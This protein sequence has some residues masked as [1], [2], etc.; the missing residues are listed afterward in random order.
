MSDQD[1]VSAIDSY[2]LAD[3]YTHREGRVFLTGTQALVRV[4]LDQR[5]RDRAAGLNT[6]GYVSGYRGSPLGG[7]D[8]ELTRVAKLIA[9]HKIEFLPAVN[10]DLAATA[11]LG[12][13]QVET[14]PDRTVEGVFGMWYGKGPGVDRSGDALKHG[15]AYGSS[16]HGGVLVVA[17]DDHGCV[18]SS[19]PHQSDAAFLSWFMP[20]LNPANVAEFLPYA[21]YGYALSRFSGMWVGFKAISETVESGMSVEL[22]PPREFVTP[23]FTAP[24]G[25]LHYRWPDLPGPQIETRME[26]KKEAVR[27]FARANPLDGAIWGHDARYGIVTTGKGHLDLMEA[28]RLLGIDQARAKEIGLDVYKVGMVWPLEHHAALAFAEDKDELLVVEEKRGIIESQLKEY[29]YDYPGRKPGRMVGKRDEHGERLIPWTGEL[30]ATELAKIVAKRLDAQIEGLDLSARAARLGQ[31]VPQIAVPGATRT[32]YF[33][34][35]CPHSTSTRVPEGSQAMAG[36][37]CHFMASWM[38]RDTTSLI[39]MGGEGVNWVSRSLFNGKKHIFQNLGEGTYYHSGS[40]AIRQAVAAGT[41]I[42]FKILYNDAVAMTG[43]QPVD[44]PVSVQAIAHEMKAEGAG[45][46]A[47]VSDAPEKFDREDF[48]AG[49]TIDHRDELDR[50]QRE[51]REVPGVTVLIYEQ[52]CATEKRRRRKRGL[53][54][55]PKTFAVINDLV[56]EGCGDC[57][58]E[59]N[60]LSVEPKE[61]VFGRK[62]QINQNTCNKDMSCLNGFCPSFVT[63]RG[64]TLKKKAAGRA[65]DAFDRLAERLVAPEM[66]KLREPYD[67]LVTGVGGTGVVT[68][69]QVLAMAAHLEGKGASVLDFMGFAQKFGPVLSYLRF[70]PKPEALNQVRIEAT[71]A[72][73]VIAC[74]LVVSSSPKASATYAEGRTRMALNLAQMPTGDFTRNRSADLRSEERRRRIAKT[75]G[76]NNLRA[77]D[78]NRAAEVLMGDSVFAN[79]MLMGAAWQMGL[80]P[81]SEPALL[82]ALELNGVAVE[83]NKRAFAWGRLAI[84]APEEVAEL[85]APK[86]DMDADLDAVI[87]RRAAFLAE[88]QDEAWAERYRSHVDAVRRAEEAAGGSGSLAEAA[89]KGLFKVMS[90]K[91]EYE[92]ARLHTETG[93]IAGLSEKFEGNFTVEHHLAPPLLPSGTD[94]RGRPRK[95]RFGGWVRK[96][97]SLLARMKRLRGTA[98]DPFGRTA[99]R[100]MER[101]MIGEYE[102]LLDRLTTNLRHDNLQDAVRIAGMIDEIRGFGPVK[103]EAAARVRPEMEAALVEYETATP[104]RKA[105]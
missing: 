90:Y 93:F 98:F 41:N 13:Q 71:E 9:E 86:P 20:V 79:V 99:E 104:E 40:M 29:F 33:C 15:N 65:D 85:I 74:D 89:A 31:N 72:D 59:S 1:A 32:P 94:R 25:G 49:T 5:R 75:I 73:A 80:A 51:L 52:M 62:R 66:P 39:Q 43:G 88:Y 61:T 17:G 3:R 26:A 95:R 27:A 30:T 16:P 2:E 48:P 56:C 82:R 96:P 12:S 10:E 23:D 84:I 68:V 63:V 14:D 58:V 34:S 42:T 101:E 103:E 70:A 35:G 24:E 76:E 7:V 97:M 11:V 6:A 28:L 47:L 78:A 22:L 81:V 91:D 102:R 19:M 92:V 18:S 4:L 21:E 8:Q 36:I 83:K 50:I 55:D 44:G 67:L 45:R 57:S 46:I 105:A 37:G 64:A 69:G 77:F 54:E 100:R 53:M 38:D 60:C 87:E